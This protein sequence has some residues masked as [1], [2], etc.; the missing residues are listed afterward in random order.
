[1][2]LFLFRLL[3]IV[4]T[5]CVVLGQSSSGDVMRPNSSLSSDQTLI[6]RGGVFQLGFFSLVNGSASGYL[7]IRHNDLPTEEAKVVW[8]ANRNKSLDKSTASLNLTSDGNLILFDEQAIVWSTGTSTE[9]NSARLQLLDSGN[10]VL[11]TAGSS[12]RTLWQSFDH[13]SDVL[14][15]GMKLGFDLR[16]NTTWQ[17][18]SWRSTVDPSPGEYITSISTRGI[19]GLVTWEGA[20]KIYRTGPWNGQGFVRFPPTN[21]GLT[22]QLN[23]IFVSNENET[24]YMNEYKDSSARSLGML[25]AD[26]V[27]KRWSWENGSWEVFWSVPQDECDHYNRCGSSSVCTKGYYDVSCSC[28]EGFAPAANGSGGCVRQ[29]PLSCSSSQVWK[30]QNVKLPDS[31][32][33]TARGQMSV[34]ACRDLCLGD[35]S[36]V[37][38]AVQG[39][40]NG[41]MT[42]RG[43]LLDL[44]D[45]SD[46]VGED[47]YVRLA[48]DPSTTES[49]ASNRTKI[50]RAIAIPL[51]LGFLLLCCLRVLI[52]RRSKGVDHGASQPRLIPIDSEHSASHNNRGISSAKT[53]GSL[54]SYDLHTIKLA[55][56]D[57]SNVNKLG[58]G[59]FGVVY[60]GQLQDGSKIAVKKLSNY[61]SQGPNEFHNELSLIAK[62]QHRNLVRL[63]GSCIEGDE[64]LIILEYMEN[65]SL[66]AFLFDKDMIPKISDFGI[67]RIVEGDEI[68]ENATT[69]PIGTL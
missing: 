47:L 24:Y 3:G 59:G 16:I 57:F 40:P 53:L 11:L 60:K 62:L 68:L 26:G 13:P 67:A 14:L 31:E 1:M 27:Y 6:S 66:D 32:N 18:V 4:A 35:C 54:S 50:A 43:D 41:C 51:S 23:F 10:L 45:F 44:R 15:P 65:K 5:A 48:G 61:S 39:G 12:S 42:W 33:A 63:L 19:P 2:Q 30:A 34:D 49:P 58:E 22:T 69:R 36:C 55:T 56:D 17:L 9:L 21:S 7:G 20:A 29:K 28:L 25:D 37:A 38:Y 46:D 64:R 8:L 52:R